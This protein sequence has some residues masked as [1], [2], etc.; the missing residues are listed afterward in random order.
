MNATELKSEVASYR[1]MLRNKPAKLVAWGS[2]GPVNMDLIDILVN[3]I[4][5]LEKRID[6]IDLTKRPKR[7]ASPTTPRFRSQKP[8]RKLGSAPISKFVALG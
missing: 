2:D 7:Q 8:D 4:S 3:A 5:F 6:A 1:L